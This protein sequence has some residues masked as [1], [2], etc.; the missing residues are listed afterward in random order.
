MKRVETLE[1]YE[2]QF[3]E[4]PSL[5]AHLKQN[6]FYETEATIFATFDGAGKVICDAYSI[7][8]RCGELKKGVNGQRLFVK[9]GSRL[10]QVIKEFIE[11]AEVHN[12]LTVKTT[13]S[14]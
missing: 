8:P 3:Y 13:D 1:V 10:E 2:I 11:Q 7:H 14:P 12:H 9:S 6:A 5:R 4:L